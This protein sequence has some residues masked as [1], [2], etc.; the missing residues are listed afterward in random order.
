MTSVKKDIA[1]LLLRV[2]EMKT[3]KFL[4]W[5]FDKI[6]KRYS[7]FLRPS[8][9][10]PKVFRACFVAV[11]MFLYIISGTNQIS[12][13]QEEMTGIIRDEKPLLWNLC[14][15]PRLWKYSLGKRKI[16]S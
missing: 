2:V 5:Q 7:R 6:E 15:M 14:P 12:F 3:R 8:P 1:Q 16:P 11:K 4:S 9:D 10:I 13:S